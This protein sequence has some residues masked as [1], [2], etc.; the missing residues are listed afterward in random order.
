M[1]WKKTA[2]KTAGLAAAARAT[3]SFASNQG[4]NLSRA[5]EWAT[6]RIRPRRK[7]NTLGLTA[8]KGLGAAA[9]ALPIGLWLGRRVRRNRV[10]STGPGIER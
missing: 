3:R 10:E 7:R 1:G 5:A 6:D 8:V 9:V 2:V 4:D